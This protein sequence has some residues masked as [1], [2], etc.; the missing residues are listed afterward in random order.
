MFWKNWSLKNN[1]LMAALGGA[2]IVGF[3]ALASYQ[4]AAQAARPVLF[5]ASVTVP[6]FR[7]GEDPEVNYYR[8]PH[9]SLSG[10]WTVEVVGPN[11]PKPCGGTALAVYD[12][13]EPKRFEIQMSKFIGSFCGT[14][15]PPGAYQLV[16][17]WDMAPI[18]EGEAVE[19]LRYI[20]RSNTFTV[21]PASP[22]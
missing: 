18:V 6:D 21:L 11:V 7:Q 2:F 3:S 15:L 19:I 17:A 5:E 8:R 9:V 10:V 16:I 20:R 14:R 4:I 13:I 12:V 1:N 22:Q